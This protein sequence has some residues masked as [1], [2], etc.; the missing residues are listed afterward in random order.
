[1]QNKENEGIGNIY[2]VLGGALLGMAI[3]DQATKAIAPVIQK[4]TSG[5]VA[6]GLKTLP[7]PQED[8]PEDKE[9]RDSDQN[10]LAELRRKLA[11]L[12]EKKTDQRD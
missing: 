2:T 6:N 4:L 1:M 12:E 3:V 7:E 10:E 9:K 8:K 5:D 11:E